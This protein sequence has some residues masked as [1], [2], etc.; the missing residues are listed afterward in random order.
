MITG[1]NGGIGIAMTL[2][3]LQEGAKVLIAGRDEKKLQNTVEY[4]KNKIGNINLDYIL[5]DLKVRDGID[6]V[7][8]KL[9]EEDPF[10]DILIN[11][12]GVFTEVDEKR[13]FKNVSEEEFLNVWD[14]NFKGTKALSDQ[15]ASIMVGKKIEG[16]II[17]VSSICADFRNYQYTPYGISKAA[18]TKYSESLRRRYGSLNICCIK[19]GSVATGMGNLG[20]G[21][22]IAK[23]CNVLNR[24]ALPEE[25]AA[26]AAF[27]AAGF[28]KYLN[29]TEGKLNVSACEV[30]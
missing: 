5:M 23:G 3:F 9:A 16:S 1:G 19:P 12:A 10:I 26:Q 22:N 11:N 28:G 8:D 13:L 18:I 17:T 30:L 15:V 24:V 2:R 21:D 27:L 20:I 29:E 6:K 4:I 14:V 25:I 7:L